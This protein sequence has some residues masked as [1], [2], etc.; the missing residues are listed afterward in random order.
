[1]GDWPTWAVFLTGVFCG[2]AILAATILILALAGG[3]AADR[4]DARIAADRREQQI[5]DRF[6]QVMGR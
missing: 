1:M 2:G 5:R 6:S 4:I 3:R